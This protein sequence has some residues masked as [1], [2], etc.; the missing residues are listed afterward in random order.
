MRDRIRNEKGSL[1]GARLGIA[2]AVGFLSFH[3]NAQACGGFFCDSVNGAIVNQSAERILF[4]Q[5]DEGTV[6]QIVEVLYEGEADKFAWILPVPGTPVPSVSSVQVFDRLQALTNPSY[7]LNTQSESCSTSGRGASTPGSAGTT[8][9]TTGSSADVGQGGVVVLDSGKVGNFDYDTISVTDP[10]NPAAVALEWLEDNDYDVGGIGE[11]VLEPYLANGLNLIAF[12]LE[13]GADVGAIQPISLEF[14]AT[15]TMEVG[16]TIPIRPT[17]VAANDDMP[18]LVW[19]LGEDRAVPTN[20]FGLEL[21]ELLINWFNPT[22]NYNDVVIVAANDAGGQGFVTEYSG[23]VWSLSADPV[24]YKSDSQQFR[25]ITQQGDRESLL[26]SLMAVFGGYDGVLGVVTDTV[27]L[28]DS[29]SAEQ[30]VQDP[31]CYFQPQDCLG[32][33]DDVV[34][35]WGNLRDDDPIY[36]LDMDAFLDAFEERVL[37]PIREVHELS[38][39]LPILTRLYTT[40]SADEMTL[41]PEFEFNSDLDPV[42]NLHVADA[43]RYCDSSYRV[44]L[45]GGEQV[46]GDSWG[47]WP[48][49]TSSRPDAP[50]NHELPPNA[51]V[52]SF[53]VSGQGEVEEDYTSA[54]FDLHQEGSASF[55]PEGS[56]AAGDKPSEGCSVGPEQSSNRTLWIAFLAGLTGLVGVRRGRSL[57]RNAPMG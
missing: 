31:H 23:D 53:A 51:R 41:D 20:Y 36:S 14:E 11:S 27:P 44:T 35:E 39:A 6:T 40:M 16:M 1:K 48:Y 17:A 3:H 56:R 43:Y 32:E 19:V 50:S 18:I 12:K 25:L 52:L 13:K 37:G 28:R 49:F 42:S 4:A 10:E 47:S 22:S 21:N 5:D 57:R 55:P 26:G 24:R 54:I 2:A 15:P 38:Q 46:F 34:D 33:T 45:T 7:S 9:G 8:A 30:F 29:F